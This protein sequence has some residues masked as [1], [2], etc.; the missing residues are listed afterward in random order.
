MA[1]LP[2]KPSDLPWS[3]QRLARP[4]VPKT[5]NTAWP[6]D[7]MD[8]FVL[9]KL[10]AAKLAPNADA[11]RVTLIRRVAYDLTGLPPTWDEV[12]DFVR[13]PS[14]DDVALAKVVD[15]YLKS[16]RF[17]ERWARHWLDV[18]RYADS[19][20]RTWNAPITYAWKYRDWVIDSFNNDKPYNRFVAEQIAG[21]LLPAKTVQQRR[22]QIIGTGLLAL[23]AMDLTEGQAERF[24]MDQVDD[25]I[26]V[27]TRA[28][29]GMTI[30]CARCH[31]HK[32]DPV[33]QKDYYALAGLFYSSRTLPGTAHKG[34]MTGAG[35]V[36]PEMLIDLPAK[37]GDKVGPPSKLPEGVHS[38][39]DYSEA[40]S[41]DR[42]AVIKY[43]TD[44]FFAIG[45]VDAKPQ[46][47]ELAVGGDPYERGAAPHRGSI[48][49]PTLPKMP[50]VAPGASGRLELA[51]WITL[52]THPMTARVMVNRVWAHLFGKG[53]VRTVDDFGMTGSWPKNQELLDHLAVRFV[54][55]G[56][57]V[58]KLIRTIMLS[59]AYRL[60]SS[61][62][63]RA[64]SE[65]LPARSDAANKGSTL[66]ALSSPLT[67][68]P[69]N[70]LHWRMAPRRLEFEAIRDAMLM[71]A[72]ELK[73]DRPEGIQVAGTGGKGNTG[74]TRS[75]LDL[76]SPYRTIYLPVLRDLLPDAYATFDFPPPT[77]IKGQRDVTTAAPQSLWFMNSGFS[78]RIAGAVAER[79]SD[80]AALYRLLLSRE[81]TADEVADAKELIADSGAAA[82]VQAL[83]GSAEFRYVF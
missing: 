20:G 68:D 71:A 1:G 47:C 56:W 55:D 54:V 13:D 73:L 27:T 57:S 80:V 76:E 34:D 29:L 23:G 48:D 53:I 21:D 26:D 59:H 66:S 37:L 82:L 35:Y 67:V 79:E 4:A 40:S 12:T 44:G 3:F 51:N 74:R 15:G 50:P 69:D 22:E 32:T 49:I 42:K 24:T 65:D 52:P 63:Q 17:G 72:N 41:A 33:T 6:K 70:D 18:V 16:S 5:Q 45:V 60:D 36:D 77:Q 8:R 19:S 10:E 28:F 31:D 62:E 25:Q 43:D 58:K 81:P 64:K 30:A 9:A 75:L 39:S 2:P 14:N 61:V 78:E 38:M 83:I 46:N 11:S 7:D